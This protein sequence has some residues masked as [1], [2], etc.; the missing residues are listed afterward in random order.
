MRV[1][2][3]AFFINSYSVSFFYVHFSIPALLS[4]QLQVTNLPSYCFHGFWISIRI[5]TR[6]TVSS[7][8]VLKYC[9]FTTTKELTPQFSTLSQHLRES[10]KT[11]CLCLC[12]YFLIPKSSFSFFSSVS[13]INSS[14]FGS[15]Y[16]FNDLRIAF[17]FFR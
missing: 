4:V 6:E 7:I 9:D 2:N 10:W 3:H 1:T 11:S 5:F 15:K 12:I 13:S 17:I 8:S 14:S 16:F